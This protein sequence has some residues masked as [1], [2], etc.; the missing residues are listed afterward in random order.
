[1]PLE[2]L[3]MFERMGVGFL[4]ILADTSD[5]PPQMDPSYGLPLVGRRTTARTTGCLN[6]PESTLLW[7]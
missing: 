4:L 3:E 7:Q 6:G 5:S 1:V 2:N